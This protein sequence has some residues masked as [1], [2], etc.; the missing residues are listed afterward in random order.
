MLSTI[1]DPVLNLSPAQATELS[2]LVDLEAR[3]ENLRIYQPTTP[4][5]VSTLKE[6]HQKQK[7][8]EAFFAKL[9]AY[10]KKYKP[11]HVP[12]LLLNNATR[13]GLWCGRMRDLLARVQNDPQ[14]HCPVHLLEKAYR[15]A[16]R[17]SDR[18]KKDRIARPTLASNIAAAIR[19]LDE[20]A[21]WCDSQTRAPSLEA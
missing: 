13:L 20:L 2:L 1:E 12:E 21:Q 15:W 10:N 5:V 14:V 4:G 16:D 6:L 7:A 17:L 11:A 9:A 19:E 18:M 8:Y 3:W